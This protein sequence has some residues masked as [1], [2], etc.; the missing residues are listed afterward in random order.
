MFNK[1][2][3]W[4]GV[5]SGEGCETI[6]TFR[7]EVERENVGDLEL[8]WHLGEV[9][10]VGAHHLAY[11]FFV[12]ISAYL[13]TVIKSRILYKI[14]SNYSIVIQ[15]SYEYLKDMCHQLSESIRF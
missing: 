12:N 10:G 1:I 3:L 15:P 11:C 5:K 6:S 8:L 4:C 2:K 13:I 14:K 7:S 9:K